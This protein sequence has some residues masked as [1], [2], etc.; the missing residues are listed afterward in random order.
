M[1]VSLGKAAR[2]VLSEDEEDDNHQDAP[3]KNTSDGEDED[4]VGVPLSDQALELL[5][6]EKALKS[7]YLLKKGEKRRVGLFPKWK[8]KVTNPII[9]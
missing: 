5:H 2:I 9:D 1:S 7:G 6:S 8:R 3:N 4:A